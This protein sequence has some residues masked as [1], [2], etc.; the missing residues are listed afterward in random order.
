[1]QWKKTG[2]LYE[3]S[4]QAGAMIGLGPADPEH[5]LVQAISNF[6]GRCGVAFQLQDDILGIVE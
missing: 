1:M 5:E 4:G 2:V 3:F 6:A